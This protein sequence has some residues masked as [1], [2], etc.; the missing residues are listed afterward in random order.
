M[1]TSYKVETKQEGKK[2]I[3]SLNDLFGDE[4]RDLVLDL[5][6][7]LLGEL[8]GIFVFDF[9]D[10]IRILAFFAVFFLF[11]FF[12][13]ASLNYQKV[14]LFLFFF[15]GLFLLLFVTFILF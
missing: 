8:T 4:E 12:F 2:F 11:A 14:A 15:L 6:L 1:H 5:K 9:F 3:V 13:L 10:S 7:G